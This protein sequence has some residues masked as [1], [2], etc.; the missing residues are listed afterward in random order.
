MTDAEMRAWATRFQKSDIPKNDLIVKYVR[1]SG[2]G[3]QNVNKVS[4]KC[5]LR[6]HV[7]SATWI[8]QFVKDT[9][10]E[11]KLN[12][13]GELVVA[14]DKFRTQVENFEDAVGKLHQVLLEAGYMAK[15]SDPAT[16]KRIEE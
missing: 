8:P 5:D 13:R 16:K 14:S 2:P 6:C 7:D 10:R 3:G 12:K 15:E 1:S 9:L 4:S 11:S